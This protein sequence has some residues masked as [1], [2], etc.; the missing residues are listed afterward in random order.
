M[1]IGI[2]QN[3]RRIRVWYSAGMNAIYAFTGS[4]LQNIIYASYD[5][6]CNRVTIYDN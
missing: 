1:P 6:G 2:P 3:Q 5:V 4:L